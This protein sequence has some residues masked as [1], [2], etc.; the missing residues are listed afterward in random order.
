MNPREKNNR[1]TN[2]N[3]NDPNFDLDSYIEEKSREGQ[4]G[5]QTHEELPRDENY[6]IRNSIAIV[7]VAA[8][9]FLWAFDWSPGNAYNFFFGGNNETPVIAGAGPNVGVGTPVTPTIP[10]PPVPPVAPVAPVAPIAPVAPVAPTTTSLD[11]SM[12]D[13]LIELREYGLLSDNKLSTFEARQLYDAGVPISYIHQI[14]DKGWLEHFS[15]VHISEFYRNNVPMQYLESLEE[16]G[17][18]FEFSFPAITEYYKAGIPIEYLQN[19]DRAGYL[20]ELSFPA[21]TEFYRSGVTNDY[22]NK[23]DEAGYLDELS[24]VYITEYFRNGVTVEFL[25]K[26]KETGLYDDLNYLDVV[27]MYKREN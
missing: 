8:L 12:T 17:Y 18:L 13:Y 15:F 4:T 14:D 20:N 26:L 19:M 27:D 11:Q 23:M 21:I 6:R 22:L 1:R 3:D 2:G 16:A 25:D 24:F 10:V 5:Q 7:I 9:M